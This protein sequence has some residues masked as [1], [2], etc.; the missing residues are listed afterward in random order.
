MIPAGK[1]RSGDPEFPLGMWVTWT[2]QHVKYV[3]QIVAIVP[4]R[5]MPAV[6]PSRQLSDLFQHLESLFSRHSLGGGT[7]R[8]R[9]SYLVATPDRKKPQS[10]PK[11][12]W[13]RVNWLAPTNKP[14][15]AED[16]YEKVKEQL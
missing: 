14:A 12:R 8:S 2:Y 13:P 5:T 3:G 1:V 7:G 9:K 4:A 10:K 16:L 15:W 11:L 6:Y